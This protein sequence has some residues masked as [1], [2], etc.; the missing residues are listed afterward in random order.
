MPDITG[1]VLDFDEL[2]KNAR[3][4][5]L[6]FAKKL[7]KGD[8]QLAEDITQEALFQAY[9]RLDKYNPERGSFNRW[10]NGI[11][12]NKW[13]DYNRKAYR[14][15]LPMTT[16]WGSDNTKLAE[17][18]A[19][20]LAVDV[21]AEALSKVRLDQMLDV[22]DRDEQRLAK[23]L[24]EDG[25]HEATRLDLELTELKYESLIAN[26]RVKLTRFVRDDLVRRSTQLTQLPV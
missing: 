3:G 5:L 8:T 22:L 10:L 25:S 19:Q 12:V 26:I 9:K 18:A 14:K 2:S 13:R 16:V 6:S 21:V 23:R 24:S 7:T 15:E 17:A 11:L 20:E 1:S 4:F